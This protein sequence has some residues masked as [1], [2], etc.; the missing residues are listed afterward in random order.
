M[1]KKVDFIIVGQGLAGSALAMALI[2]RGKSLLVIDRADASAATRVAAGLVTP[3]AGKGMNPSWRQ[4]VY[5][6]EALAY[7]RELESSSGKKLLYAQPVLRLFTDDKERAKFDRKKEAVADWVNSDE[8]SVD[9]SQL[10]AEYGGFEMS[11]GGRLD[12]C[13]YLD[14]VRKHIEQVS[15]YREEDFNSD[16]IEFI[17]ERVRWRDVEADKVIFCQ[18]FAGLESGYFSDVAHRSAKGEMLTVRVEGLDDSRILSR[19][20]WMVPLGGDLWRAGATYDWNDLDTEVTEAGLASIE[21]KVGDFTKL[22]FD[23]VLHE[24]GVRPIISRS[25]PVI[26]L[27]AERSQLGFFNGL[28]SKGVITSPSVGEHFA[29]YLCGEVELDPELSLTRL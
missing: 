19:N 15:D 17:G 20:G 10:H 18:G 6:P 27:H 2:R 14:V 22:P 1:A 21:K 3:L 26:G 16:D 13:T 25:Q 24:A 11:H 29:A 8:V 23:T 28:G 12:T 7:Y 4:G 5:L 9:R